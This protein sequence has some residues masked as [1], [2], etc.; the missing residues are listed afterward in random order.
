[1]YHKIK[2]FILVFAMFLMPSISS[3]SKEGAEFSNASTSQKIDILAEE[4]EKLKNQEL[5]GGELEE[6]HEHGFGPAASKVYNTARGL[7][8]GGYG[9]IENKSY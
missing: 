8:I 3:F 4:I 5:F 1:M 2:I 9:E 7:A 6:N